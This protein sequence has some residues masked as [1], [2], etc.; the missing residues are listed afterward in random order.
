MY[1]VILIPYL[2]SDILT[3][4]SNYLQSK[5]SRKEKKEARGGTIKKNTNIW[6]KLRWEEGRHTGLYSL[7]LR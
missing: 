5:L 3:L 4:V 7:G 2:R 6:G 1:H